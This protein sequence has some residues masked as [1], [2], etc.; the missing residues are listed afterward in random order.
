MQ[1]IVFAGQ[2]YYAQGGAND[3]LS[4]H[5]FLVDAIVAAQNAEYEPGRKSDWSHVWD[6]VNKEVIVVFSH[7]ELVEN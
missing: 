7:G 4:S 2:T 1:F 6:S 3:Y 5:D